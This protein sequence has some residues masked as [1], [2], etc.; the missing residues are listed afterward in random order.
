M[1]KHVYYLALFAVLVAGAVS[2]RNNC[3]GSGWIERPDAFHNRYALEEM[4]VLSR[5]NIRSPLSSSGSVLSRVTP[6]AWFE[7]TSAPA[8]LSVKGGKLETLMGRFFKDWLQDEG[9][10]NCNKTPGEGEVRI[11]ANSMQRTK[12]T[13]AFFS[14]A[15]FPHAGIEPETHY[16]LET[17]D[18]VFNPVTA[19]ADEAFC[20]EALSQIASLGG[21]DDMAGVGAVVSR[22]MNL[23]EKTIDIIESPAA[24]NDT[25]AFKTDDV[26]ITI[27]EGEEPRMQGG[28]K[29]ARAASEAL[30]LQYYE[31]TSDLAAG[32]GHYLDFDDWVDIASV[33]G[34][35]QDVL[36]TTPAIARNAARPL[37]KEIQNE[38]GLA[39][40]KFSFLCGHDS[41]IC[42][43]LSALDCED[44]CAPYAIE[45]RTPIGGKVVF[46][47]WRGKDGV[48]YV[49]IL[50]VYA[51]ACQ[52][53]G[54][55][56]LTLNA[57][58]VAIPLRLKGLPANR[59]GL[60]T[61]HDLQKR[62]DSIVK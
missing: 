22:Q 33:T 55:S 7:W 4:V 51:S 29:L 14:N 62:I 36:F 20:A 38:L 13:A 2:C 50:L 57:P 53:R 35:Y 31:E 1:A 9:L 24:A 47:K 56:A 18:P 10:L 26:S 48:E 60:Y 8:E 11:Y 59:D 49:D 42:T 17:M 45:T 3:S 43:V 23:L 6:H 12:A 52:I 61:L 39:G 21:A 46:E 44:Y 19:G 37:L 32:F 34:W 40:R 27:R 41:N 25:T 28:L 30:I 54:E 58:P 16:P 15:M 5:H